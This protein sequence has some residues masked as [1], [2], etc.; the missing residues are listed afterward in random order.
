MRVV[1]VSYS[2]GGGAG[3]AALRLHQSLE[4]LGADSQSLRSIRRFR[5]LDL[6]MM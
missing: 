4:K 2:V 6:I 3:R 5:F 1:H